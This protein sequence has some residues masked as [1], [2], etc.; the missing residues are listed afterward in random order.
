MNRPHIWPFRGIASRMVTILALALAPI[1]VMAFLQAV[2]IASDA[3]RQVEAALLTETAEAAAG[4][5]MA[6]A[7]ASG[8]VAAL[9]AHI[10]TEIGTGLDGDATAADGTPAGCSAM[11]ANVVRSNPQYSFAGYADRNGVVRCGSSEVGTDISGGLVH[12]PMTENPDQMVMASTSG[13]VSQTSV[14]VTAAPVFVDRLYTG[15]VMVSVPHGRIR[16]ILGHTPNE[17]IETI[18]TFN[19]AGDII[20]TNS[21][22]DQIDEALPASRTL[23]SLVALRQFTFSDDT[24]AGEPRRF[25]VVPIIPGVLYALGSAPRLSLAWPFLSPLVF[26]ALMLIAG[27]V[28]AYASVHHLVIRHIRALTR[29]MAAYGHDRTIQSLPQHR[30]LPEEIQKIDAV[31]TDLAETVLRDEA[32]LENLLHEKNVLLKEVHHRVKNNL[33]LIASIVNLK[34][35]RA[36]SQE[37]RRS[38]KEVQMRVMSIA[39]V[40]QALYSQPQTGNVPAHVLM[41]SVIDNTIDA[42]STEQNRIEVTRRYDTV[43]L[44]PDQA[45]PFLLMVSEAVTNALKYMGRLEDGT[46]SLSITLTALDDGRA[47]LEVINTRGTPFYPPEQVRGSGLGQSLIGGFATQID[48]HAETID[49][50]DY[51]EFRL[52]FSPAP[53]DEADPD[54]AKMAHFG[55]A[56]ES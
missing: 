6:I 45:V 9:A 31:W 10:S 28:A 52:I 8:T 17:T 27:L 37:A 2:Q 5:A 36:T 48:G 29:H 38:L 41:S 14:I 4:E 47:K 23:E 3:A 19:E 53:F 20:S 55:E 54:D 35:R 42:G 56:G 32:N 18:L 1:G 43:L 44:Y 12:G 15:F 26:P 21:G 24:A 13:Q 22:L 50:E 34:I 16:D 40:H 33:Q 49:D 46:A 39:S 7:S 30:S 51:Y 25:A 11:F